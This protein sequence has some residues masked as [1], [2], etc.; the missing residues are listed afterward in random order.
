M[1]AN[2]SG[3]DGRFWPAASDRCPVG[4]KPE[5]DGKKRPSAPHRSGD[6]LFLLGGCSCRGR[7]LGVSN[8]LILLLE[9]IHAA[10]GV[11]QLLASGEERVATGADF[12]AYVALVGRARLERVSTGADDVDF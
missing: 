5:A 10:L 11:D 3:A 9:P 7:G 1:P 8:L 6:R 2:V 4:L 12:D